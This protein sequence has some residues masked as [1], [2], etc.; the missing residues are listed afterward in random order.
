MLT[1]AHQSEGLWE[2]R[3]GKGEEIINEGRAGDSERI[4]VSFIFLS[5]WEMG[6][7]VR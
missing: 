4:I 1:D 6:H 7:K 5:V 3:R 2:G